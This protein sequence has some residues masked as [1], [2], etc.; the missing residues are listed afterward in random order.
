MSNTQLDNK[1]FS[2]DLGLVSQ[3]NLSPADFDKQLRADLKRIFPPPGAAQG[4]LHPLSGLPAQRAALCLTHLLQNV[5]KLFLGR[6]V[7]RG[8]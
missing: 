6:L 7:P 2:D 4:L 3:N 8:S 5:E 1:C